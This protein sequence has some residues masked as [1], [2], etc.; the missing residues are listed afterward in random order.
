MVRSHITLFIIIIQLSN[1]F[2]INYW[3]KQ[4]HNPHQY[5]ISFPPMFTFQSNQISYEWKK[6]MQLKFTHWINHAQWNSHLD[7]GGQ[8]DSNVK[9]SRV[10][11]ENLE[12]LK[13]LWSITNV[14]AHGLLDLDG[15]FYASLTGISKYFEFSCCKWLIFLENRASEFHISTIVNFIYFSTLFERR[16]SYTNSFPCKRCNSIRVQLVK[17]RHGILSIFHRP[18]S[19]NSFILCSIIVN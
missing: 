8:W 16:K 15:I 7:I 17:M 14:F 19:S 6:N 2:T 1:I 4:Y 3:I 11:S 12:C 18:V 10:M 5:L 9:I 13:P